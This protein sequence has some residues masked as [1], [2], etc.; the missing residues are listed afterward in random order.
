MESVGVVFDTTWKILGLQK[1]AEKSA[2]T[3]QLKSSAA[4]NVMETVDTCK[5]IASKALLGI[6]TDIFGAIPSSYWK[7]FWNYR[8][9]AISRLLSMK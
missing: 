9:F 2:V 6:N 7:A 3:P 1:T 5:S 4:K 8:K